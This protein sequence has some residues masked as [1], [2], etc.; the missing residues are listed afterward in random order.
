MDAGKFLEFIYLSSFMIS[1]N[2]PDQFVKP[3]KILNLNFSYKKGE[4]L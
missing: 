3:V 1:M 4:K 2:F